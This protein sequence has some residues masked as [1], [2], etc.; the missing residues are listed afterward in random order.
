[1]IS[2]A[3]FVAAV[4]RIAQAQPLYRTG[5][6][7]AD[8]TCDCV[9]LIMGA[10]YQNGRSAYAMHSSNYF[11]RWQTDNLCPVENQAQLAA[12]DV[13]YK[14]RA[15]TGQLHERYLPGGRYDT[16]DMLD[17]YHAGVVVSTL[18]FCIVHCTSADGISGIKRDESAEG[19]THFGCVKGVGEMTEETRVA[20]VTAPSGST[21]NLR[22]RPDTQSPVLA[23][24]PVG[25]E[26]TLVE[27]V[28]GWARV[29]TKEGSGYMMT[30]FLMSGGQQMVSVPRE[31]LQSLLAALEAWL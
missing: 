25:S 29:R 14:V 5:G 17:Y 20:V 13:V 9:G 8:G 28:D 6:T 30:A 1:M 12:G 21:V 26:A 10:M 24:V 11:A 3:D 27:E 2:R 23:R 16:G 31:T 18:P 7:G 22:S 19:W 4:E 15:N